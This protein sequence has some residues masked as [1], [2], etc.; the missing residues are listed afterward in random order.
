MAKFCVIGTGKTGSKVCEL[1]A[2]SETLGPFSKTKP[3]S[4]NDLKSCDAIIVFI[5]A[6]GFLDIT[7]D[8]IESQR[9]VVTGVTGDWMIPHLHEKLVKAKT[10]WIHS[11]N[12]A[13]GMLSLRPTIQALAKSL[14]KFNLK[15]NTSIH[16]I[17][18]KDKK[19]G[20]SGTALMMKDW[21][22][23]EDDIK[24]TF[25]RKDDISGIHQ[26]TVTTPDEK[27]HLSHQ[28]LNR[29]IFAE[30]AIWTAK[31]ILASPLESGL[32]KLDK[33]IDKLS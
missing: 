2:P 11:N 6:Q 25:D 30:G 15:T 16:E 21:W 31:S 3:F 20:P 10:S 23:N 18:H 13:P 22:P 26:L 17:H 12:F 32:F 8:L 29:T 5:P 19:D 14:K 7:Q 9:P 24:V 27:I 4:K 1:L 33:I 28:A